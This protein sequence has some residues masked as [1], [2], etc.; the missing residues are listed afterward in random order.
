MN[1]GSSLAPLIGLARIMRVLMVRAGSSPAVL[2]D[3]AADSSRDA[4]AQGV[5]PRWYHVEAQLT[6]QLAPGRAVQRGSASAMA[7]HFAHVSRTAQPGS[8]DCMEHTDR[9][10][11]AGEGRQVGSRAYVCELRLSQLLPRIAEYLLHRPHR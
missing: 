6:P 5:L 7:V 1:P 10:A 11:G 4:L 3:M 2:V 8:Y 9:R